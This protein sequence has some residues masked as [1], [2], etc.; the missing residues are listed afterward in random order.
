M[1]APG[2]KILA[3]YTT[4]IDLTAHRSRRAILKSDYFPYFGEGTYR[5]LV[6]MKAHAKA[7]WQRCAE[8]LV[9]VAADDA[10]EAPGDAV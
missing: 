5:V 8:S 10:P 4:D 2:G 6:H 7:R 3:D 9:E 1:L